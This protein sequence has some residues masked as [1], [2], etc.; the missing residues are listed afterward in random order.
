MLLVTSI[1]TTT[2]TMD[3]RNNRATMMLDSWEMPSSHT[4]CQSITLTHQ[5]LLVPMLSQRVVF[6][7]SRRINFE[8]PLAHSVKR[9]FC[10]ELVQIITHT[11]QNVLTHFILREGHWWEVLTRYRTTG[12]K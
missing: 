6:S 5:L 11:Y 9:K 7:V 4:Q 8:Q 10:L 2:A 12:H 1:L 3:R